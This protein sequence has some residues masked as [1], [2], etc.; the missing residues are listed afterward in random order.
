MGFIQLTDCIPEMRQYTLNLFTG[1]EDNV[2]TS[3]LHKY[4]LRT[5]HPGWYRCSDISGHPI[6][7]YVANRVRKNMIEILVVYKLIIYY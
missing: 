2:F 3:L 6:R 1:Y 5:H 4:P 7:M